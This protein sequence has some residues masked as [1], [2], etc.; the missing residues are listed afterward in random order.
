[1]MNFTNLDKVLLS[2]DI[3]GID[4]TDCESTFVPHITLPRVAGQCNGIYAKTISM[5]PNQNY[6]YPCAE[7]FTIKLGAS[8][9]VHNVYPTGR[10]RYCKEI[11]IQTSDKAV[12]M[13]TN[14]SSSYY[15]AQLQKLIIKGPA[16]TDRSGYNFFQ[17]CNSLLTVVI[18]NASSLYHQSTSSGGM[19]DSCT[20]LK[21]ADF[22]SNAA[23]VTSLP[24]GMFRNC[25]KLA[26]VTIPASC[27][28]IY[29]GAFASC[30]SLNA[31]IC[32]APT[33]P[34]FY[35]ET[36]LVNLGVIYVPDE[37]V[38]AY[39]SATYWTSYADK[40]RPL[41]ELS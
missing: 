18:P 37:S 1:M 14:T 17:Y 22:G 9:S 20:R 39:K 28:Y 27:T 15:M 21:E 33:P 4:L 38:D 13:N 8:D 16:K 11:Y 41:S 25:G 7:R 30:T 23:S 19:F 32:Y 40:I 5:P 12:N 10:T 2:K 31:I 34:T 26:R 35:N 6:I 29:N 24:G 3:V 36:N